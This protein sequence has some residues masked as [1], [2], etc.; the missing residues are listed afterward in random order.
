M[1]NIQKTML[2]LC[3]M[4][5]AN[6]SIYTS[7]DEYDFDDQVTSTN[8]SL[9]STNSSDANMSFNDDSETGFFIE[10]PTITWKTKHFSKPVVVEAKII[11]TPLKRLQIITV[12]DSIYFNYMP[13][14]PYKDFIE[15]DGPVGE[16]DL[17]EYKELVKE[18]DPDYYEKIERR[19][20][21]HAVRYKRTVI[22]DIEF[23]KL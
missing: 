8:T 9:K 20:A 11:Y 15:C 21:L 5:F 18:Y 12:P 3:F 13:E 23:E 17:E 16:I 7:D 4:T 1:K 2:L 22:D 19:M 14:V 10:K 6:I